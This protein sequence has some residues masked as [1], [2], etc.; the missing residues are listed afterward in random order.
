MFS[1]ATYQNL[2]CIYICL[3]TYIFTLLTLIV[4]SRQQPSHLTVKMLEYVI[5]FNPSMHQNDKSPLCYKL[6]SAKQCL[7]HASSCE[8]THFK[9]SDPCEE[10]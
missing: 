3:F 5:S 8:A 4:Y 9:D 10:Y 1:V 7:I 2:Q 6:S